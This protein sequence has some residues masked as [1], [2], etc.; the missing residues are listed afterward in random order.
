M[1]LRKHARVNTRPTRH[2]DWRGHKCAIQSQ[3]L[4]GQSVEVRG[5]HHWVI[6]TDGA[7]VLVIGKDDDEVWFWR[8]LCEDTGKDEECGEDELFHA[9]V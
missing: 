9:N 1:L 7:I 2:A 5:L 4:H 3:S 8:S 6:V